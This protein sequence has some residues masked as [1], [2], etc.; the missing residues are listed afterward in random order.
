MPC[1]GHYQANRS[2]LT[3]AGQAVGLGAPG[4]ATGDAC[5][6]SETLAAAG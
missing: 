4:P 1:G 2:N 6:A 3:I 5:G